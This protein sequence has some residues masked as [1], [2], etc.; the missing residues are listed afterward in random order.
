MLIACDRFQI[1]ALYANQTAHP[2]SVGVPSSRLLRDC[3]NFADGWFVCSS[4]PDLPANVT[5]RS[6]RGKVNFYFQWRAKAKMEK[7]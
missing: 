2:F 4:T 5:F 6:T 3:E 7:P 1:A